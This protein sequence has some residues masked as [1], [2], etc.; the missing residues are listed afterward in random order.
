MLNNLCSFASVMTTIGGIL[1]A[2]I[3]FAILISI[4]ELGHY[5]AGKIFKFKINE[6]SLGFG[7][8][9]FTKKKANGEI[10]SIRIVPLGGYCAFEGEE[11]A[12]EDSGAYNKQAWWK[13]LIV[14][15]A[16][17]FFN[18]I[19]AI[20]VAIPLLMVMG[21]AVPI[22]TS[23]S[24]ATPNHIQ[25]DVTTLQ[26]GD[27]ILEIDGVR[28]TYTNGGI[29]RLTHRQGENSYIVTIDRAG[30]TL[31]IEV[32]NIVIGQDDDGND[33]YGIG[34]DDYEYQ[35]YDFWGALG[36]TIPFCFEMSVDCI[37]IIG[38]LFT[39]QTRVSELGG[40]V[41]TIG[42]I[43]TSVTAENGLGLQSLLLLFPVIAINLAVFNFLPFPALDGGRAV[44]VLIEGI[45]RKPISE[46][47]EQTIHSV[48]LLVLFAFVIF[49]DFLQIFN[50][51]L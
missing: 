41:S 42:A 36:R 30:Q 6:F 28:P 9:I 31:D 11:G 19:S 2:F 34:V 50:I 45:R 33:V 26:E 44:F 48:G 51:K 35:K 46:K 7:K 14:L 13:R 23:F 4:H 10:F 27:I 24:D 16:G 29:S 47:V 40:P 20:I 49:V 1:L 38:E 8:A 22:V 37:K 15:F 12:S 21:D 25:Y 17:V 3:L 18:F 32:A 5:T 43:S 39:G